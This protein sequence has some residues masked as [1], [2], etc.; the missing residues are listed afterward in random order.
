[1]DWFQQIV[2]PLQKKRELRYPA[3]TIAYVPPSTVLS[4]GV[5]VLIDLVN[6]N[7]R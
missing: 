3:I 5:I 2:Q 1:M 4:D 6:E 7:L